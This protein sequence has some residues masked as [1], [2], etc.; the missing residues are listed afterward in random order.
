M[1][2]PTRRW[3]ALSAAA[4]AALVPAAIAFARA[5]GGHGF[6]GGGGG[7][8]S[9]GG[10]SGGHGGGGGD[11]GL[12]QLIFWLLLTH[13]AIGIPITI[14][15]IVL[16][17]YA[18]RQGS[19][20]YTSSVIRR[21]GA[22]ISDNQRAAMLAPLIAADPQFHQQ[23][24]IARVT[25]AFVKL[26][27]AWAQQNLTT[28]RPFISDGIFERFSLQFDEQKS[29]GFRNVVQNVQVEEA[30]IVKVRSDHR[31]DS[32]DIRIEARADDFDV[33]LS[34]GQKMP[35]SDDRP[36]SFVEIWTFLRC[37]GVTTRSNPTGLMEGR[38]PNCG[39]AVEMNQN[40][41]CAHCGAMLR[42]GAYDW[43][44][45]EITQESEWIVRQPDELIGMAEMIA[46]DPNFNA[47]DLEDRAS[48]LFWRHNAAQRTGNID[49]LRKVASPEYCDAIAHELAASERRFFGECAVGSV[50]TRGIVSAGEWDRTLV[51]VRWAG[52]QFIV[53]QGKLQRTDQRSMS[54]VVLELSRRRGVL[55]DAGM[56]VSSAHCPKCGAPE[57]GGTSNAC[58]FCGQVLNDGTR[59]WILTAIRTAADARQILGSLSPFAA[60]TSPEQPDQPAPVE[61]LAWM[62]QMAAADGEVSPR[63]RNMLAAVARRRAMP[64][65]QLDTLIAAATQGT[66]DL[67]AP[68]GSAQ[69]QEWLTA[70]AQEAMA[71]GNLSRE[72]YALLQ[73]TGQRVGLV[74]YDIRMLIRRVRGSAYD[75]A[76]A[77]LRG[78][79]L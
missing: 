11:G 26:Q 67:P 5:G 24:L 63:E 4:L 72:E 74:D 48:V 35:G 25:A 43:V 12:I 66:L 28:V 42:S 20:L 46:R 33:A 44:L 58:E 19:D 32:V 60:P 9:G 47:A 30:E 34:T 21:G 65:T 41:N 56:A 73:K 7:G 16:F 29:L 17:I 75:D 6:S 22:I 68:K 38:C 31:F 79:R 76:K 10:F 64:Q 78:N 52:T 13:P 49:I 23:A 3:L 45:V 18:Q 37:R 39:A 8:H 62:I 2:R 40:A 57:S 55:T 14:I 69:A 36:E 1:K 27:S 70:M 54:R 59:S 61:A 71:D 53:R 15:V 50:D 51:E 77:A